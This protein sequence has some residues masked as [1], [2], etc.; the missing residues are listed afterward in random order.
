MH[1]L[2]KAGQNIYFL[3]EM[4]HLNATYYFQ[5]SILI[6]LEKQTQEYSNSF[7]F[8]PVTLVCVSVTLG[9]R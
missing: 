5:I 4:F 2:C 9:H 8:V 7:V 6:L 1:V 3:Y